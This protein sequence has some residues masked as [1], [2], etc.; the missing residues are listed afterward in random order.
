MLDG[1]VRELLERLQSTTTQE[2]LADII[3]KE[4]S[5]LRWVALDGTSGRYLARK[6]VAAGINELETV[7][8]NPAHSLRLS[9]DEQLVEL[10]NKLRQD[11]SLQQKLSDWR[12]KLLAS[13]EL[14]DRMNSMWHNLLESLQADLAH[15][16]SQIQQKNGQRY[17]TIWPASARRPS[18]CRLAEWPD[19][20]L[21]GAFAGA[22]SQRNWPLY[23]RSAQS[24]G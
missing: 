5:V 15:P 6:L 1:V 3:A 23:C 7:L 13:A 8:V 18:V 12:D 20:R 21:C 19:T 4:F 11:P 9:F 10:T 2:Y 17:Q 24:L 14:Q 22:L 16:Q